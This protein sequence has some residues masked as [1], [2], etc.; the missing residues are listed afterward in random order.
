MPPVDDLVKDIASL[1]LSA[2]QTRLKT[3]KPNQKYTDPKTKQIYTPLHAAVKCKA[4]QIV[5]ALIKDKADVNAVDSQNAT[6]LHW[7]T[8]HNDIAG[9]DIAGGFLAGP[10]MACPI[11]CK[12]Q[13]PHAK[14]KGHEPVP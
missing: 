13:V 4:V 9:H 10:C 5:Q 6:P 2:V 8:E 12:T 3:V 1:K 11:T 7:A 14:K